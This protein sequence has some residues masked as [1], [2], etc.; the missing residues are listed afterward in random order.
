MSPD[1]S[2]TRGHS[3]SPSGKAPIDHILCNS[4]LLDLDITCA[5][6]EVEP[7]SDHLALSGHMVIV[8]TSDLP[9][10][11]RWPRPMKL[12]KDVK[13]QVIWECQGHTYAEW[14]ECAVKW[15]HDS[16]QVPGI[17]KVSITTAPK[18]TTKVAPS[19]RYKAIRRLRGMLVRLE[20]NFQQ[21]L[22]KKLCECIIEQGRDAPED[23]TGASATLSQL[24]TDMYA[25][26]QEEALRAW[27][28][29]TP[30]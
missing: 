21:A 17:T 8:M 16:Y 11:W 9:L 13:Q 7:I 12:P 25:S 19:K 2:T 3:S 30:L 4:A 24:T 1:V 18:K 5:C 20:G 10:A 29:Y 26:L 6:N 22:W 15:L 14:A 23:I 27:G 28:G